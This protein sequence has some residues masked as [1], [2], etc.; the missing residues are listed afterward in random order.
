MA[1]E[2]S[3]LLQ[4]LDAEGSISGLTRGAGTCRL[5]L[6]LGERVS[7]EADPGVSLARQAYPGPMHGGMQTL[8]GVVDGY[9]ELW[10]RNLVGEL[11]RNT[12]QVSVTDMGSRQNRR[13]A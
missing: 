1:S 4:H 13:P 9:L 11:W 6:Q 7:L 10:N 3:S 8:L 12:E 5:D 2:V